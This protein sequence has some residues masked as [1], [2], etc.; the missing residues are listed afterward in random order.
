MGSKIARLTDRTTELAA[1]RQEWLDIQSRTLPADRD[2]AE[3]GIAL[4]YESAGLTPPRT[5]VWVPPP[6]LGAMV[7]AVLANRGA[8]ILSQVWAEAFQRARREAA[9]VYTNRAWD[10]VQSATRFLIGSN[11]STDSNGSNGLTGPAD[12]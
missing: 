8:R 12:P 1:I 4:A 5:V 7:A 6:A 2:E 10:Q 11:S 9:L 3:V